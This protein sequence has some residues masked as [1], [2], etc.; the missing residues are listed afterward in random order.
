MLN[1]DLHL[2]T[3]ASRHAYS[4]ILE[5][6]NQA[7]KLKMK[8]IGISDHGP[9]T[10]ST[11][12]DDIYFRTMDRIPSYVEGIRI[13]KGAEANIINLNGDIDL[14]DKAFKA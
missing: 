3:I 9:D 10:C 2:H 1:I 4:T 13:L 8:V 5:Y 6:I 11:L 12:T 14:S 7:K